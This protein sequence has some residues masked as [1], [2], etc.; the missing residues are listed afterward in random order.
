M[1]NMDGITTHHWLWRLGV[2]WVLLCGS[3]GVGGVGSLGLRRG[4]GGGGAA[5]RHGELTEV[6]GI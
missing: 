4:L 2:A 6:R 1:S 5:V 3:R